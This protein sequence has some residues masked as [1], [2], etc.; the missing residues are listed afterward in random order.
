MSSLISLAHR[1]LR[2]PEDYRA[3][4][5]EMAKRS[6]HQLERR[7]VRLAGLDVLELGAG[8]GGYSYVLNQQSGSFLAADLRDMPYFAEAGIPFLQ[9][10]ATK[11]F[12]LEDGCCDLIYCSSLIE[13][14]QDPTVML[15]ECY[16]ILKPDGILYLSFP[17][18]YSLTLVGGHQFKPF[19]L[20]GERAAIR[21]T[22]A[23]HGTQYGSY[24]DS[25]GEF[26]LVPLRIAT[27]RRFIEAVG[28][29]TEQVFTRLFTINTAVLPGF[30]ADLLTWHACFIARRPK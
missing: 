22:N 13:H 8:E 2:S 28:F 26:G 24:V 15:A 1:R 14:L 5:S 21:L 29:D 23:L 25:F 11:P 7:G 18:F 9:L 20:L 16:R 19:H 6:L 3:F 27:V 17:P 10:D 4:Q 30:L 12:P